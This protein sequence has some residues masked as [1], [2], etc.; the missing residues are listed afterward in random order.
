MLSDLHQRKMPLLMQI[1]LTIILITKSVT[2]D[3]FPELFYFFLGGLISTFFAFILLFINV[4]ASIHMIALS[5]LTFFVT[6]LS[7]HNQM[8]NVFLIALL[9]FVIGLVASSRLQMKAHTNEELIIGIAVGVLPQ[10]V[11]WLFWL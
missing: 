1:A 5:A 7:M 11:L 3:R 6:G 2:I 4:K 9:F 8:N 10:I